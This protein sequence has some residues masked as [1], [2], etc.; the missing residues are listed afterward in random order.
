MVSVGAVTSAFVEYL[1]HLEG[2]RS[3]EAAGP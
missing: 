2:Q 1:E 3:S